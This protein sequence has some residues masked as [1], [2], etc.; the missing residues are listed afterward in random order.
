M[1][2]L[3]EGILGGLTPEQK[4]LMVPDAQGFVEAVRAPGFRRYAEAVLPAEEEPGRSRFSCSIVRQEAVASKIARLVVGGAAGG[5]R[6][7]RRQVVA[8]L[9]A[10]DIVFGYGVPERTKRN[11]RFFTTAAASPTNTE[12]DKN[13]VQAPQFDRQS[14]LDKVGAVYSVLLNPTAADSYSDTQQLRLAL[15]YGSFLPS[16]RPL[17][18]FVWFSTAPPTRLLT[19][20][21]NPI[22][23]EGDKPAGESSILGAF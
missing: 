16:Q 14:Q 17:A 6:Q 22:S 9:N 4:Q 11:L 18:D 21:K 8:V 3:E 7:C 5:R 23:K 2:S 1:L 15:A 13:R 20:A 10:T 19:R 12:E